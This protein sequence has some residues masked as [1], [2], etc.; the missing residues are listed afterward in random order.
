MA[1]PT[2]IQRLTAG[3]LLVVFAL[4]IT[5]K[6]ALH[7]VVANHKDATAKVKAQLG[8]E[9]LGHSGF[10]CQIENLVCESPFTPDAEH[11]FISAEEV[12]P[13]YLNH[14]VSY[15]YSSARYSFD[16]RGPPNHG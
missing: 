14:F 13:A 8:G 2:I 1:S 10:N 16:L 5:P 6:R 9:Q 7:A 12:F 11:E 4:A 3:L 15:P